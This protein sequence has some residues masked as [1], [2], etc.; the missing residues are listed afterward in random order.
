MSVLF[1]QALIFQWLNF[2][3]FALFNSALISPITVY[4][5]IYCNSLIFRLLKFRFKIFRFEI[6]PKVNKNLRCERFSDQESQ[7]RKLFNDEK[8]RRITVCHYF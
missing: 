2:G 4:M 3:Q 1:K 6:L 5:Y 8:K 7:W